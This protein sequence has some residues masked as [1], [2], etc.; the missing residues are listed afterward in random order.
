M[1]GLTAAL[2]GTCP[3]IVAA[4]PNPSAL[5]YAPSALSGFCAAAVDDVNTESWPGEDREAM[6]VALT[7]GPM[8]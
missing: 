7:G 6:R 1:S 2:T 4:A 8:V 3:G 5:P